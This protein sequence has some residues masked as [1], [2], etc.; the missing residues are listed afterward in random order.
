MNTQLQAAL[1]AAQT[2][3]AEKA[4]EKK[5]RNDAYQVQYRESL[6]TWFSE[7][8]FQLIQKQAEEHSQ[9]LALRR[10]KGNEKIQPCFVLAATPNPNRWEQK[11]AIY[12][13]DNAQ[14]RKFLDRQISQI[15]GLRLVWNDNPNRPEIHWATPTQAPAPEHLVAEGGR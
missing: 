15:D 8:L 7:T 2:V 14:N 4:A 12:L 3:L 1:S 6:K 9:V 13:L 5:A 11:N 10:L